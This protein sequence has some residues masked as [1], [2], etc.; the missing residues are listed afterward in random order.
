MPYGEKTYIEK[1]HSGMT[2]NAVSISSMVMN[3]QYM[4]NNLPLNRNP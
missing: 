2:Y 1:S 4:L 3:Q